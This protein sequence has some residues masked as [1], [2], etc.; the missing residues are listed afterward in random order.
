MAGRMEMDGKSG[1][2]PWRL[3]G[4]GGVAILLLL[5]RI[6]GAPWTLSDYVVMA[7]LLGSA[8]L[9]LEFA[10]R[11]S[12]SL[13]FRAGAAVAVA[14]ALL[15]VWVNLAVGFLGSEDNAANLIF[16]GVI[17]TAA[18]GAALARLRP[19]GMKRAML[20]AAGAQLL[21]GVVG[22]AAGWASPGLEGLYEVGL[23]TTLFSAMWLLSAALFH[24]AAAGP[25]SK[26]ART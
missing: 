14:A 20:A 6:A 21:A 1:T 16:L 25:S 3:I 12:V 9:V 23:G 11:A 2:M 10:L 4:W 17:A 24:K 22:L 18:I 26:L 15:L 8:G 13:A 5:P 19:A 7:V